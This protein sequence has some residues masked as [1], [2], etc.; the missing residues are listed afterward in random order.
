MKP[1][2]EF[3]YVTTSSDAQ[4]DTLQSPAYWYDTGEV[5]S[6]SAVYTDTGDGL[7]YWYD[8]SDWIISESTD[9][10]GIPVNYY[11]QSGQ[12]LT[13]RGAWTGTLAISADVIS[14]AWYRAEKAAFE[15]FAAFVGAVEGQDCFRGFLPVKGDSNDDQF[16]NVWMMTSG[17]SSEFPIS[18]LQGADATWCSLRSDTRI[19]S[20]WTTRELAM[21]FAGTVCAW[22]RST[23]NLEQTGNVTWCTLTDI[24]DEPEIY[25][26]GGRSNRA[27]LWRQTVHLDLVYATGKSYN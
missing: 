23:G 27:R 5:S 16:S 10:G 20:L 11:L 24:P 9:V 26:T 19:E 21:K 15:S 22:L 4:P 25:R 6:G 7:S 2:Y 18:R 14:D 1:V 12:E 8:G 13:G 17:A 3:S